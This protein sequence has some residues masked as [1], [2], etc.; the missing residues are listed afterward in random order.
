MCQ[1]RH[2]KNYSKTIYKILPIC[3]CFARYLINEDAFLRAPWINCLIKPTGQWCD[4]ELN[5][6]I[7][8]SS[9]SGAQRGEFL[10]ETSKTDDSIQGQI[11]MDISLDLTRQIRIAERN[12]R[13]FG[14]E[15]FAKSFLKI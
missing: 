5:V 4:I 3:T 14:G 1:E 9:V 2:G 10:L 12:Y 7:S 13:R 8:D 15:H 11:P 6:L